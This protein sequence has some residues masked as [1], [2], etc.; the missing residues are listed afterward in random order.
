MLSRCLPYLEGRDAA[1][2]VAAPLPDPPPPPKH[3]CWSQGKAVPLAQARFLVGNWM[4]GEL[5][6]GVVS[7]SLLLLFLLM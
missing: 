6:G 7:K 2:V 5:E 1:S 3:R 4:R